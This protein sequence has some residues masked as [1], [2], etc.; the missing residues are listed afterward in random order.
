MS[1]SAQ[2]A[3]LLTVLADPNAG[4]LVEVSGLL[5]PRM[6]G[7]LGPEQSFITADEARPETCVECDS[8]YEPLEIYIG[9]SPRDSAVVCGEQ[10]DGISNRKSA[11]AFGIKDHIPQ[12][13]IR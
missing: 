10:F 2:H 8:E 5:F 4:Y 3:G 13:R 12:I 11:F 9:T 6:S 1:R 7:I